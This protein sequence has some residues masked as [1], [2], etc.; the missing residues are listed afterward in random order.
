MSKYNQKQE[1]ERLLK[2]IHIE[3][4][5]IQKVLGDIDPLL[6]DVKQLFQQ[7][8][9]NIDKHETV[10][11]LFLGQLRDSKGEAFQNVA[12]VIPPMVPSVPPPPP[13]PTPNVLAPVTETQQTLIRNI[14]VQTRRLQALRAELRAIV[15]GVTSLIASFL[16]GNPIALFI[17]IQAL[18]DLRREI[19]RLLAEMAEARANLRANVIELA[20]LLGSSLE[21]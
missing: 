3:N 11:N 4:S 16:I 2:Q 13:A 6:R 17:L 12:D 15:L 10:R 20:I 5:R 9:G 21:L 18:D 14:T 19:A 7:I 1:I 8:K